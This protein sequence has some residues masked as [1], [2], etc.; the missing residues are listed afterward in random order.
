MERSDPPEVRPRSAA[1]AGGGIRSLFFHEDDYAMLELMP[2]KRRGNVEAEMERIQAFAEQH[3]TE[4][5]YTDLYVRE[6]DPKELAGLGIPLANVERA[7]SSFARPYDKVTTGYGSTYEAEC[8]GIKA[9]G[10]DEETVLLCEHEDGT[11]RKAWMLLNIG[12]RERY[13]LSLKLLRT[14][15]GIA[16]LMLADLAWGVS[17]E[18]SDEAAVRQY[19]DEYLND[20]EDA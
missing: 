13:D 19:L 12:N 20:E 2:A 17:V 1:P 9:F 11:L 14:L 15:A 3:R 6:S 7:V 4:G 10:P 8:P 16:P 5:G 18:L